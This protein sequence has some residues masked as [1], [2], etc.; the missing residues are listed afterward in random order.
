MRLKCKKCALPLFYRF[1]NPAITFIISRALGTKTD[2]MDTNK[3]T[4]GAQSKVFI[5]RQIKDRGKFS[6]VTISTI[7]DEQDEIEAKEVADSFA[8]NAKIIEKQLDRRAVK[9][10]NLNEEVAAP[11]KKHRGTL[12]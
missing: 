6:S 7:E 12:L 5:T 11:T 9:N 10:K 8:A 4:S 1:D 2:T 3:Q